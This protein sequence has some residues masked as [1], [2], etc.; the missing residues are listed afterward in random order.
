MA[1][2]I[3]RAR[4][5]IWLLVL[6]ILVLSF[7]LAVRPVEKQAQQTAERLSVQRILE[8]ANYYRQEWLLKGEPSQANI[9]GQMVWFSARGWLIPTR[10]GQRVDC[11]VWLNRLH[12]DAL[13]Q[14]GEMVQIKNRSLDQKYDCRYFSSRDKSVNISLEKEKFSVSVDFLSH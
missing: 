6:V 10:D 12:E 4:F 1:S 5:A 9:D 11:R 7:L 14:P 2:D 8:R 3:A 13:I